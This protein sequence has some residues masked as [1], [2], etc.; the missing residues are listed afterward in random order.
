MLCFWNVS[1]RNT[2]MS[3]FHLLRYKW[4]IIFRILPAPH[5][6]TSIYFKNIVFPSLRYPA[7]C[8][9]MI[10]SFTSISFFLRFGSTFFLSW[11]PLYLS[12]LTP[13]YYTDE[14]FEERT[15]SIVLQ[16]SMSIKS[17]KKKK[18][19]IGG[20]NLNKL[21]K[22]KLRNTITTTRPDHLRN[23]WDV[24]YTKSNSH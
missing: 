17:I 13:F 14:I 19:D 24:R 8:L 4:I 9:T 12:G 15:C 16:S 20:K 3:E 23:P 2:C 1:M 18:E 21:E 5:E 7:I 6:N 22:C 10:A 11:H